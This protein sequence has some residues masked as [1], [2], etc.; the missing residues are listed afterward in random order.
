MAWEAIPRGCGCRP[1][2]RHDLRRPQSGSRCGSAPG[3]L[4]RG[5]VWTVGW[6]RVNPCKI[7]AQAWHF[8]CIGLSAACQKLHKMQKFSNFSFTRK[9]ALSLTP[10]HVLQGCTV[11][12][13]GVSV[14]TKFILVLFIFFFYYSIK[15]TSLERHPFILPYIPVKH[16]AAI[17][18]KPF[19]ALNVRQTFSLDCYQ[20]YHTFS[21]CTCVFTTLYL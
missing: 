15:E 21:M 1:R 4:D 18:C 8:S 12:R 2:L 6:Y 16:P 17:G 19:C 9:V 20:F 13:G 14:P 5:G 11:N 3:R 7:Y 10:R